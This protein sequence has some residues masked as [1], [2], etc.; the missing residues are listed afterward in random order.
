MT[1]PLVMIVEDDPKLGMIYEAA[2]QQAGYTTY[3]DRD[4][5]KIMDKLS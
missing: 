5:D 3:L 4:G 1:K 2:L